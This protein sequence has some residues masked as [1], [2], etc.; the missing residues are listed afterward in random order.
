MYRY[1]WLCLLILVISLVCLTCAC[2]KLS[3]NQSK[4]NNT[5]TEPSKV[6]SISN[7]AAPS[8]APNNKEQVSPDVNSGAKDGTIKT[9]I[10]SSEMKQLKEE[11]FEVSYKGVIING[12]TKI[13]DITKKLGFPVD[14]EANNQGYISGNSKYRRWNLCYPNYSNPE[15]RI[16]VLSERKY[17]G[18]E[19]K[20]G[21][22]YIVGIYLEEY[23]TNR[24]LKVGD[25]LAKVLQL[26]G[27]PNSF[28]KD[29][30]NAEAL[31]FL[32]YSKDGSNLDITLDN[33]MKK[34]KYI[35]VDYNMKKSDEQQQ[36]ANN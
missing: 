8:M 18:E 20:D 31:Y 1:K 2:N 12:N 6:N 23:S 17:V 3:G 28:E 21:D 9:K 19:V 14:Y 15:I 24:G 27:K 36:S 7:T 13:E 34:V 22:S 30:D 25:E 29:S 26:Y 10:M 4:D 16:I 5:V 32:R 35:F 33:D 11:D